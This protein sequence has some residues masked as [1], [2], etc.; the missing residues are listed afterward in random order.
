MTVE[1]MDL[2]ARSGHC[3]SGT[4]LAKRMMQAVGLRVIKRPNEPRALP[5]AGMNNT[6]DVQRTFG[7]GSFPTHRPPR[8]APHEREVS[9]ERCVRD[10]FPQANGLLHTSPGQ[11]PGLIE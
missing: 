2:F 5:W 3:G 10:C 6:F 7:S 1:D 11:R 4:H 8:L 9:G